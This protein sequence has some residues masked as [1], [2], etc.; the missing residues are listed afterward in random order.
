MDTPDQSRARRATKSVNYAKEQEFSDDDVFEDVGQQVAQT[1]SQ[2]PVASAS[3]RKRKPS[4][5]KSAAATTTTTTADD[6]VDVFD[7]SMADGEA[8][9]PLKTRYTEKG[10][11]PMVLPIRDRFTFTPEFEPDGSPKIDCIVGRRPI[12]DDTVI[13]KPK[14]KSKDDDSDSDED[15]SSSDDDDDSDA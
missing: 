1:P 12:V 2:T 13:A 6:T 11:D 7:D 5:R 14:K 10:Y 15:A 9:E 8:Y 3:A 4:K